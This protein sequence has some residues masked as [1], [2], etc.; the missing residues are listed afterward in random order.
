MVEF[1]VFCLL[2]QVATL[3]S[4]RVLNYMFTFAQDI[5]GGPQR[6]QETPLAEPQ[7]LDPANWPE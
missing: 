5:T 2:S 4:R 3:E 6:I 7:D 1:V